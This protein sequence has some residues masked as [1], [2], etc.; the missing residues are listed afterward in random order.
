MKISACI[1]ARDESEFLPGCLDTLVGAVDEIIVVDTGSVDNTV[2]IANA[3][4]ARVLHAPWE[5]DFAK[6]RNVALNAARGDWILVIDADERLLD[7]VPWRSASFASHHAYSVTLRSYVDGK[8]VKSHQAIRFFRNDPRIRYER[9]VHESVEPSLERLGIQHVHLPSLVLD[10]FGYEPE[11]VRARG[12]HERNRS[13]LARHYA[14][15]PED[16]YS[17]WKYAQELE[18]EEQLAV[19]DATMTLAIASETPLHRTSWGATAA[20]LWIRRLRLTGRH[21]DARDAVRSLPI[22][23]SPAFDL[24][25]ALAAA[26]RG[27]L[28]TAWQR[29]P[30]GPAGRLV[31]GR[32]LRL[33]GR[34]HEALDAIGPVRGEH[35]G[36]AAWEIQAAALAEREFQQA[37]KAVEA[38]AQ[39]GADRWT[40]LASAALL[41]DSGDLVH[42]ERALNDL[43]VGA[44]EVA[45]R[46]RRELALLAV[47]QR[48]PE[49]MDAI[50]RFAAYDVHTASLRQAMHPAYGLQVPPLDEGLPRDTVNALADSWVRALGF[51]A[52]G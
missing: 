15:H 28:E 5:H 31:R 30:D 51:G 50:Q 10:H 6:A 17:S 45:A 14:H 47:M 24:E 16:I 13:I 4:G 43:A 11:V 18:G 34:H 35:A 36:W 48:A 1:I 27:D 20:A 12:K 32:V 44:D 38:A 52:V 26:A 49:A 40:R 19:L 7:I 3:A 25:C 2:A 42:A 9:P 21:A 29:A 46:A 22:G 8:P 37:A 33:A 41:M 39:I 23:L